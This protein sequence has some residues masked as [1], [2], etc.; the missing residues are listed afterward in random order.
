MSQISRDVQIIAET[1]NAILQYKE[2]APNPN[3]EKYKNEFIDLVLPKF[4]MLKNPYAS[5]TG[6]V[7]I[8]FDFSIPNSEV[9]AK[10]L[11]I[12]T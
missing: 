8:M 3:I 6:W 9:G 1:R 4:S 11:K 2:H 7:D 12:N 5:A 10:L